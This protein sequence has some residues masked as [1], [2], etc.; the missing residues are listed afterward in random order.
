MG[1]KRTLKRTRNETGT[2]TELRGS[3][4]GYIRIRR[5]NGPA[6]FPDNAACELPVPVGSGGDGLRSF[7]ERVRRRGFPVQDARDDRLVGLGRTGHGDELASGFGP[8]G[9]GVDGALRFVAAGGGSDL[10]SLYSGLH[11]PVPG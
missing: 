5:G 10:R 4:G 6:F 2:K 9:D 7:F 1:Q 11:D 8:V 3:F